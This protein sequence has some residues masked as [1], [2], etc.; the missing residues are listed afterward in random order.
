MRPREIVALVMSPERRAFLQRVIQNVAA[1]ETILTR[2]VVIYTS[3]I[4]VLR[5]NPLLSKTISN[6]LVEGGQEARG[7]A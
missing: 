4:I 5:R 3:R 6:P 7:K 1:T 2:K